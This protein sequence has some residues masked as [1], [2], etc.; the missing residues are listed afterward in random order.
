MKGVSG[1]VHPVDQL[2]PL[3][4]LIP[5]GLQHV[6][7][8][9]AGAVAVAVPLILAGALGLKSIELTYL[10]AADLFSCGIAT[11]SELLVPKRTSFRHFR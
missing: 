6:L 10:V 5:L 3:R 9:Y 8:M 7:A 1:I 4:Q 11:L 2:L